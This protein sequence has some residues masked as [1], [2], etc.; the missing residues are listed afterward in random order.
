M[1]TESTLFVVDTGTGFG[2][3]HIV[4][5]SELHAFK[6]FINIAGGNHFNETL[7][8][9]KEKVREPRLPFDFDNNGI[10]KFK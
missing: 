8:I 1:N 7:T 6:R 2:C 9:E 5:P 10:I 3:I 4:A